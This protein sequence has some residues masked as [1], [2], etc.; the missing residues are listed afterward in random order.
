VQNIPLEQQIRII[1]EHEGTINPAIAVTR[2][3]N[4]VFSGFDFE[5]PDAA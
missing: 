5:I 1:H 4:P 2:A 3:M